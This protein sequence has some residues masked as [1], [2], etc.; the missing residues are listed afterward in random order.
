MPNIGSNSGYY[1]LALHQ[2]PGGRGAGD[3]IGYLRYETRPIDFNA[4]RS[5]NQYQNIS[6]VRVKSVISNGYIRIF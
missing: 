4:A 2:S 6:E 5:S 3:R 1:Q